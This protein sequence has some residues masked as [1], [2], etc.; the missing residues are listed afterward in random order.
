MEHTYASGTRLA[1][2]ITKAASRQ[3]YYTIRFLVDRQRIPDAYRAYAYFRWVDDTLDQEGLDRAGRTAF[4]E[5]Q[6]ALINAC[7]RGEHPS[8]PAPEE[9]LLVDLVRSDP[10]ASSPLHAY[11]CN[12]M[13]VMAF[14]AER[15][16]RLISQEELAR[17][18]RWLATAVTEAMHYFIGHDCPTP[19]GDARYQAVTGA[20][21]AHMLRDTLDDLQAGYYNIPGEILDAYQIDPAEIHSDPYRAWVRGRVKLARQCFQAGRAYLQQVENPRCRFAGFA[22]MARFEMVL[23]AMQQDRGWLQAEYPQRKRLGA[24]LKMAFSALAMAF[25]LGR[26][27]TVSPAFTTRLRHGKTG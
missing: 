4:L 5:R 24:V 13:A 12:L 1:E 8:H 18:T 25:N 10:Q 19:R 26:P 6:T 2:K 15:R 16:C 22:Y 20:H 14:D 21:I 27:S 23:D 7:Y 3:T 17:Y 9:Q 11:I